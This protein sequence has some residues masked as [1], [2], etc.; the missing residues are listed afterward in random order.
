M[1][2]KMK[3]PARQAVNKVAAKAKPASAK[4]K[5]SAKPAAKAAAPQRAAQKAAGKPPAKAPAKGAPK[6][7]LKN[8]NG[9]GGKP[10]PV[11][12]VK[13]GKPAA[14]V[15]S[16]PKKPS[17]QRVRVCKEENCNLAQT[18]Q[19]FCRLHYLQNWKALREEKAKRAQKNLDRYVERMAGQKKAPVEEGEEGAAEGGA[20]KEEQVFEEDFGEFVD[21]LSREENL[22]K[23]L[24]GIKVEDY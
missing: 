23:I 19:G 9:K 16:A 11:V 6:G 15:S 13:G 3:K 4:G 14:A 12:L 5:V 21:V 10:T 17:R 20:Q 2:K 7:P 1:S 22:D 24:N 8:G 18:T